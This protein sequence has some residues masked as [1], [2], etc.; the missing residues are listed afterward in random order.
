LWAQL[1][2]DLQGRLEGGE[3]TDEFPGEMTL[4][5][6]YGVSRN[7]VREAVRRLRAD[8]VVVAERGRR[9]RLA[10][11]TEI[12]QPLGALYSLFASVEASG[13]EQRSI[14]RSLELRI[15]PEA[16][17]HLGLP[18]DA[19]MLYLERLRLAAGEPL[20]VDRVWM[21][22]ELGTPLLD[23]DF[24]HTG[25]YDELLRR[26]GIRL[27]GGREQ[28]RALVPSD[29]DSAL[30]DLGPNEAALAIDRLGCVQGEPV[31]WRR[32]IVRGDRFSVTAEFSARAGYQLEV[33]DMPV[34]LQ[35]ERKP[36][37]D[38]AST[39]KRRSP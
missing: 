27:T 39:T 23:T 18:S 19:S 9:P 2:S 33:T 30:L 15:D 21:S 25:F 34:S 20:A 7:T 14:V 1:H 4:V 31:E 24:S 32:T 26:V 6:Q 8:G 10:V 29:A 5:A 35:E 17:A 36:T 13:L 16:A 12:E 28:I 3:F 37:T 38:S 11:E 22:A